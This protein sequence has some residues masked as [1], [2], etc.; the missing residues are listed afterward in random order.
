MKKIKLVTLCLVMLCCVCGCGNKEEKL[1]E[2][3]QTIFTAITKEKKSNDIRLANVFKK[4]SNFYIYLNDNEGR[5]CY[6][7]NVSHETLD[8]ADVECHL[9]ELQNQNYEDVS[10][11]KINNNLK[12][13][14]KELGLD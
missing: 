6:R 14:W 12:N 4:D 11:S 8:S 9:A 7:I 1:S 10:I 5:T 3:E 2:L 13:Y